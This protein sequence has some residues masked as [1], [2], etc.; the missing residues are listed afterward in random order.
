MNKHRGNG[1]CIP[2]EK[3]QFEKGI[4]YI[5]SVVLHSGKKAKLCRQRD[6]A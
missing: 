2:E 5:I 6:G 4:C 3:S 1:K